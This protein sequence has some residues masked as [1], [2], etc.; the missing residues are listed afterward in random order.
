VEVHLAAGREAFITPVGPDLVGVAFLWDRAL[1]PPSGEPASVFSSLLNGF[2]ALEERFAGVLPA[3]PVLGAGPLAQPVSAT[4]ARRL[5]LIGDA[6]GYREAITGEG[7][8]LAF[9]GAAALA[10]V[11]PGALEQGATTAALQP[12]ARA[13]ARLFRHYALVT[14]AVLALARRPSLRR[15]VVRWLGAHPVLLDR[16]VA[17]SLR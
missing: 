1:W 2:P 11:V 4:V 3:T 13:H 7:L 17:W 8:S 14:G 12:Y 10:A 16:L 9:A 15:P 6:A 5:V